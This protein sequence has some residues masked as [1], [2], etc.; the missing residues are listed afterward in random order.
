MILGGF[1]PDEERLENLRNNYRAGVV[2]YLFCDFISRKKDKYLLLVHASDHPLFLYINSRIHPILANRPHLNNCQV[3]LK[4]SDYPDVITKD[5]FIDCTEIISDFTYEEVEKQ[6]LGDMSR[7]K[8]ALSE[9]TLSEVIRAI[10]RDRR[11][12][13]R[14]KVVILRE[15]NALL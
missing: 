2:F 3:P 4:F 14:S 1:F 10:E 8:G 9:D 11:I 5:C 15:L 6:V 13:V 12:A 7:I